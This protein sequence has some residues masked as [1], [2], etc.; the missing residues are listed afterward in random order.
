MPGKP[1]GIDLGTTNSVVAVMEGGEPTVVV[2]QEGSRTTPSVVAFTKDGER[3]VGQIAKR[4]A[5]T[6]P[7]NTIFSIKRFMG[8]KYEEVSEEVKKVPYKVV[9]A[10]NGDAWV[11]V[12]G[13]T[14]SPPEISALIL[15]KL[16][17]AAEAYLGE[18]VTDAVITV[19][20]YF[21]DAQ[22][23]ATKDA[24]KIA[25]L[26]VLR[27]INEPTAAALAYGLDKKKDE[28]IAVYDFGGGTFDISVLEVGEGVV[29]VKSTNGDTHLGGDD[30][31]QRIME[32]IAAEFKK[33]EGIDLTQDRMALQRLKE[34]AEKAKIELS[35]AS[36]TEIN[37]PFITADQTGPKHLSLKLT[38]AKLE[39]LVDDLLQ[40]TMGPVKQALADAGVDAKQIDED[41]L[42]GG[43]TR[44]PRIQQ[45][46]KELFG[47]EPHKG[48]NPD[49][50]VAVG[51]AIQGGVLVGDVKDVLLLD[52][53]PL[54]LGLETLG[55]VMTVLIPRNTTIPARKSEL[56]STAADNQSTVEI[57]VL[58]GERPLAKDNRTLG[59]FVLTGIPPAP[60]GV[61]QIEVTFDI[62]ANG[63]VNVSA[64]DVATG[65]EQKI[66]ITAT[67]GLS[68]AEVERMV[69]EA[70]AHAAEDQRRRELI[71]AR[72]QADSL[73]YTV[74]KTL[75]ES[76]ARVPPDQRSKLES[77]IAE[78]RRV[79]QGEDVDAIRKSLGELATA[80]QAMA[81]AGASNVADGEV[82]DAETVE[83]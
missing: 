43:M 73:A 72:N 4:Q 5:I 74:E 64:K 23:Q 18:K 24:G 20:A 80:S 40:R 46:V 19:P 22:R 7:E 69:T 59:R 10:K 39:Q 77:L 3:L 16:K 55:G 34:G 28:T 8:R 35:T 81:Q 21:N 14:Y 65:K 32:W 71:E 62:D 83:S 31:D 63:I 58:Q 1:I 38:R 27:I 54:S 45:L 70:Q 12:R 13:K 50:V 42:V 47:K 60:R 37:L 36:E 15:R 56:F 76:E 51:A 9:R 67:S 49:E 17:E 25:D 82:V 11:E 41:V 79:A 6:N 26:N 44:M 52:V 30:V 78:V 66:T 61:P 57:H 29:E 48:V 75:K 33:S 2:N 53:T 68:K